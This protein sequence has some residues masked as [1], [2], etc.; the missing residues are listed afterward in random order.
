MLD[1]FIGSADLEGRDRV[2]ATEILAR[3]RE[4]V[5]IMTPLSSRDETESLGP[6]IER[7]LDILSELGLLPPMPPEL[8]EAEGEFDIE[9]TNP[10]AGSRRS[11][12][13]IGSV[14][15]VQA[16]MEV[17]QVKPE[18][19]DLINVDEYARIMA[20]ANSSPERLLNSPEE[21]AS[22]REQRAEQEAL[23]AAAE[24]APGVGRGLLDIT[25]AEELVNAG[26]TEG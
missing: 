4:R 26:G 6:M 8:V 3:D 14:Q 13:A 9:F 15:T 5:R 23:V 24:A 7:E 16:I 22:I 20:A 12:E 11:D 10:L 1:L 17:G 18:A 21:V 2:T 19:L 25:K